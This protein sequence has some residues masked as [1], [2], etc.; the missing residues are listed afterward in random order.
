VV[1]TVEL[2]ITSQ[3]T[4]FFKQILS[5]LAYGGSSIVKTLELNLFSHAVDVIFEVQ[6]PTSMGGFSVNFSGQCHPFPDDQNI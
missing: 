5:L 4:N 3:V 2:K 6:T 1:I